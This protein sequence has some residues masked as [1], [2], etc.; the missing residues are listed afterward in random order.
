M[1]EVEGYLQGELDYYNLKGDTG[2]LVYPAGFVY[3]Y[4]ILYKITNN[5]ID[6]RMAQWI[7]W[8]LYLCFMFVLHRLYLQVA[9]EKKFSFLETSLMLIVLSASRRIHSLFV[10]RLFNDCFAMFLL[11]LAVWAFFKNRWMFGC[12]IYSLAVSIKM[13]VLLFAPGLLVLLLSRFSLIRVIQHLSACALVQIVLAI[14]FISSY[15]LSYLHRAFEFGRTFMYI[16]SVNWKMIPEEIF[17]SKKFALGLLVL[18][19]GVLGFLA[20]KKWSKSLNYYFPS[21]DSKK[22]SVPIS[23]E[24]IAKILFSSNF[25][26]IVFS[27]SLHYQ[28]YVWYFHTLPL[29]LFSCK[30]SL[31]RHYSL[32]LILIAVL[33]LCW[34]IFPSNAYT[35]TIL[36][37]IHLIILLG[38]LFD[39]SI[40]NSDAKLKS[41]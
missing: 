14:P 12:I 16:W 35:S 23:C 4:S 20:F 41:Q 7:F 13:N 32:P 2:P 34:N 24:N 28:F 25:I 5:G 1:Q 31:S 8:G 27:R 10:L 6:I 17:L 18:H 26:G 9:E 19:L 36:C 40:W 15:P 39:S 30:N 33:E 11:Y 38:I 37:S 21:F 29:L 3:L 22:K